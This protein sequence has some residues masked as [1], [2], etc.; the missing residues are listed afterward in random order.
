[1]RR[2]NGKNLRFGRAIA[3]ALGLGAAVVF[4]ALMEV[5]TKGIPMASLLSPSSVLVIAGL[6]LT[7]G[8]GIVAFIYGVR[9]E[10]RAARERKR[11]RHRR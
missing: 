4:V 11:A 3:A 10:I 1:M 9:A 7:I 2:A 5:L 6:A 8:L